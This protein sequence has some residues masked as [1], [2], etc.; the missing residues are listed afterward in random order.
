MTEKRSF[1]QLLLSWKDLL[2][3]IQEVGRDR[4]SWNNFELFVLVSLLHLLPWLF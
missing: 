3:H 4:G 1:K 2:M